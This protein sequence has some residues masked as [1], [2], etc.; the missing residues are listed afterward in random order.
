MIPCSLNFLSHKAE[1]AHAKRSPE[2]RAADMERVQMQFGR[3]P[4]ET[5]HLLSTIFNAVAIKPLQP[6]K[7]SVVTQQGMREALELM[8][9]AADETSAHIVE[10]WYE[11]Y[12][13]Q[14]VSISYLGS[15]KE[16][17]PKSTRSIHCR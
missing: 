1:H 4:P 2:E 8:G 13:K 9:W 15:T 3:L 16:I 11:F 12:I 14:E 5:K 6:G 10:T 7:E 17:N